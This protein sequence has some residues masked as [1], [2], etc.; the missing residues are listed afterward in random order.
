[1]DSHIGIPFVRNPQPLFAMTCACT[2]FLLA[3]DSCDR[4]ILLPPPLHVA[5]CDYRTSASNT[6][7]CHMHSRYT[8]KYSRHI[9]MYSKDRRIL[10][11]LQMYEYWEDSQ[12][13]S[14]PMISWY[15]NIYLNCQ[16]SEET[17]AYSWFNSAFQSHSFKSLLIFSSHYK[18]P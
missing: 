16:L 14:F 4:T 13:W 12:L 18:Q 5:S 10:R 15:S 9:I 6:Q 17:N 11:P 1:M 2:E 8:Q 7:Y 3:E